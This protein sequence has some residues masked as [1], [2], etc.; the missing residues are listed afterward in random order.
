MSDE[1]VLLCPEPIELGL[2]GKEEHSA[3]E[4]A[5]QEKKMKDRKMKIKSKTKEVPIL[6]QQEPQVAVV[7]TL[8][9]VK[10]AAVGVIDEA[11]KAC[12]CKNGKCAKKYCVC[13]KR[14]ERCNPLVCSCR[15]CENLDSAEAEA[16]RTE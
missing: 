6:T 14:A 13:L 8:D 7:P 10:P 3:P 5:D 16:R 9:V 4:I 2:V 15:D 1:L 11:L 12:T